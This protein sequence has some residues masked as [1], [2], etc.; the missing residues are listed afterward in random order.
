MSKKSNHVYRGNLK[1]QAC[2]NQDKNLV[3]KNNT[4]I[5]LIKNV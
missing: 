3:G 5:R 1:K 2:W 4:H